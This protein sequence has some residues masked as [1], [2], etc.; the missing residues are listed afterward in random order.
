MQASVT[1]AKQGHKVI[2]CEKS[3]RLGGA[4]NCEEK[5]PFKRLL[6]DYLRTQSERVTKEGIE[7][8]LNTQV[9]PEL[10]KAAAPD[11]IISAMGAAPIVP[12]IKGIDGANVMSAEHAYINPEK[13]GGRAVILGAGLVGMELAIYLSMLGKNV[14][15]IEML[16]KVNDGGNYQHMKALN[17][18]FDKYGVDVKLST[19]AVEID[20]G[21]VLCEAPNGAERF[22][23]DTVIYAVGQK[24]LAEATYSLA[25]CA[26]EFYP[27]GDCIEPKNIM[28]ATSMA[29]I[30][31]RSIGRV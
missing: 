3:G 18:E 12:N 14:T 16:D 27:I 11:V 9:T 6:G 15:I 24:A 20:G 28:N 8:R 13:V 19:K 22:D 2:L 17:V 26:P 1:C 31:A 4:L 29:Y 7:I 21:G 23:A 5:V 10:A 25:D 30:A